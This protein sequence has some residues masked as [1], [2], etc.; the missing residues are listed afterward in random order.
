[1]HR[2]LSILGL[3]LTFAGCADDEGP[4]A[5]AGQGPFTAAA[6]RS[7]AAIDAAGIREVIAEI[8]ADSYAGRDP[9]SQGDERAR[10]YIAQRLEEIGFK[11][12]GPN[13]GWQQPFDLIGIDAAQPPQ[14]TFS[15]ATDVVLQQNDEFIAASGIQT[16]SVR[17]N[18]AEVV[19][20][21][22]GIE[23]PEYDWNDFKGQDLRGKVLLMLNSDPDWD[24]ALFAGVRRLYYG[25]WTYKYESAAR[26]GAAGAIIIHTTP[27][28][29]YPWQVV[30]SSWS[31]PQFELPAAGEPRIQVKG[32]VTEE[33]AQKIVALA[34]ENLP[35]LVEAAKSRDF[36][37]VPLG[38]Q[39]SIAFTNRLS[40]TTSGNVLGILEG[41]DPELRDEV[42]IY[43]AHHDHL[44]VGEPNPADPSD[45]IYNGARDNA[46]GVA[47]L[48]AIGK[49]FAELEPHAR[50]SVMLAFVGAEEQGLLGS[51]YFATHPTV[52]PAKMATNVNFDSG[53]IWGETS[54]ITFIGFG[55][56]SL[57]SV[58][59][60]VAAH[61][62]RSVKPD[63][64]PDRGHFYRSDQFNFAKIG[65]PAMYL[66]PGTEFI[67]RPE[68]WGVAK[69]EEYE[70]RNYHQP[71]DELTDDWNFDGMI[72]DAQF[73]FFA[74]L[75]VADGDAMPTWNPGDEFEAARQAA[76]AAER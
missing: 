53:N 26:Q 39:T 5:S 15:A 22:Y 6:E 70:A 46:S 37:P 4:A 45:R 74:G 44:G 63:Q 62:N 60:T 17:V 28:A 24:P 2:T 76:L 12:A 33:A 61:Q 75:I 36:R 57:D 43:S 27:S 65:V 31:G 18:A 30:Q 35:G 21:G 72:R 48:L 40:Q 1:M 19:F 42:V 25:R 7:A 71:S 50:R 41:S 73:G 14:W 38:V 66:D 67:G 11:P 32:W 9:G 51:Q 23:A 69:V 16:E 54:D 49:A 56:S 34:G 59:E 68:G 47:M 10:A 13:G 3:A 58:A 64:F 8:S 29:G 52:A 20:V 55:K